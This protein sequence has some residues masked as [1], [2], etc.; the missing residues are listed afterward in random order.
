METS[1]MVLLTVSEK[2]KRECI[3]TVGHSRIFFEE[4]VA[5]ERFGKQK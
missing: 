1:L 2:M 3:H 5:N 4:Y